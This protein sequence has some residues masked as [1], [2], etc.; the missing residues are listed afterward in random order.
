MTD[1]MSP[2]QRRNN[3]QMIKSR[4]SALEIVIR[5]GLHK[6][7]LRYRLHD[8]TLPGCPDL[9]FRTPRVAVFVHGCF[10]HPHGC[11]LSVMPSTRIDFW[12]AKLEG[13]TSRDARTVA[14]L[15]AK[16]WRVLI[17]RECAIRRTNEQKISEVLDRAVTFIRNEDSTLLDI[18]SNY[19]IHITK[20]MRITL[21]A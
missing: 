1:V 7:G 20:E 13:N 2:A 3:M 19:G 12:K 10:W 14:L 6:R 16:Q 8:R 5:S 18:S 17:I 4:N 9:V 15:H 21:N 11:S